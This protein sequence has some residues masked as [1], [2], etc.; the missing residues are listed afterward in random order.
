MEPRA[1][2]LNMMKIIFT[3]IVVGLLVSCSE[4]KGQSPPPGA[5]S[6]TDDSFPPMSYEQMLPELARLSKQ[7]G[8]PNLKTA[9]LSDSQ[10]EIRLWKAFG[11]MFPR[12]FVLRIDHG[13]ATASFLSL[14]IVDNKRVLYKGKPVYN[15]VNLDTPHSGWSNVL[16]YL[17]QNG[18]DSSIKLVLDK[19]EELYNDAESLILEMK[20][21][22]RYT[23]V[24]YVDTTRSSDGKKAFAVCER[25]QKEFDVH[26]ACKL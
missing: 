9:R 11:L 14:K 6:V 13:N 25:I 3:L 23:L 1:T 12:C 16:A 21:G 10:T 24:H 17:N 8:I 5:V 22:S 20:S 15:N 2:F 7:V 26:L 19:H 4:I 18:I